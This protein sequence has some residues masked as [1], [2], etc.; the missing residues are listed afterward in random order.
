MPVI[1]KILAVQV[2]EANYIAIENEQ[3]GRLP[4][5][6]HIFSG[7]QTGLMDSERK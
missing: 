4:Q 3:F 2:P 7:T 6:R 1:P 5:K